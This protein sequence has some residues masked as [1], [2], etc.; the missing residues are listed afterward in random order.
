M[1]KKQKMV[2]ANKSMKSV[3]G[4]TKRERLN[5]WTFLF[6]ICQREKPQGTKGNAQKR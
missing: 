4:F 6:R 3:K 1:K 2:D 5:I